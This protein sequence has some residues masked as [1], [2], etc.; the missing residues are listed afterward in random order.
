MKNEKDF[1]EIGGKIAFGL[2]DYYALGTQIEFSQNWIFWGAGLGYRPLH[3]KLTR[4]QPMIY[5]LIGMTLIEKTKI[6]T[7]PSSNPW[8]MGEI[9]T[10]KENIPY[11]TLTP[12]ISLD[13]YIGSKTALG[14]Y[15][16]KSLILSSNASY[17]AY[18]NSR[19]LGSVEFGLILKLFLK[20]N[21]Y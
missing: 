1:N 15:A 4:F 17:E 2:E 11:F 12:E 20:R 21:N 14:V 18:G 6:D 8:D 7:I 10:K 16:N 19:I 3:K 13:Y 9:V 5:C